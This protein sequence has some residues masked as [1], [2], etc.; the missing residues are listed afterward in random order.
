MGNVDSSVGAPAIA[1]GA[2][3]EESLPEALNDLKAT[4]VDGQHRSPILFL[5]CLLH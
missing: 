3:A 1:G 5:P 4:Q 2:A